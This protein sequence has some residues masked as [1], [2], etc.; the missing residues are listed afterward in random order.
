MD[1]LRGMQMKARLDA[2]CNRADCGVRMAVERTKSAAIYIGL[3]LLQ[4]MK[5]LL[6][7]IAGQQ[8]QQ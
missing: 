2:H 4:L 3:W 1:V 5:K 7:K 6:M 8:Q